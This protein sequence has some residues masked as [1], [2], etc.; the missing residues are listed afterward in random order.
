LITTEAQRLGFQAI[1]FAPAC[2]AMGFDRFERWLEKGFDAGMSYLRERREAYRHPRNVL[3]NVQTI[4][5]L[6]LSYKKPTVSQA[7]EGSGRIAS[8]ATAEV[9]YHD[10]IHD[11]LKQ[12]QKAVR[13]ACPEIGMRGIVDTAPLLEREYAQL[14]GLGW[15]GKNTL[16]LNRS[17]GSYFFLAALLVDIPL[18][19]DSAFESDHCGTCRACL[20]ACPTAAFPEPYVLDA[21]KCISYWTI[22]HRG[23]IPSEMQEGIGDWLF[24]CD[25]CQQVC[26]W[27]RK[28]LPTE[29]RELA[30]E[31]ERGQVD[32][33]EL[34]RMTPEVFRQRYRK[35]PLW[36]SKYQG[37]VRNAIIVATNQRLAPAL[38]DIRRLAQHEDSV[39][40]TTAQ[41]S[42]QR[43]PEDRADSLQPSE[44]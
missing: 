33:L 8:Y 43:W 40:A 3:E 34:L 28:P 9:D 42:L 27:N 24:G 19:S 44:S 16:L 26:P 21:G 41:Q 4:V 22:E 18:P 17:L 6:G 14:A 29:D 13:A 5:M 10:V 37:I 20:D 38:P 31:G 39:I 36:R 25:V 7:S 30:A 15:V 12:L 1:G 35:T 11:R 32:L 2:D 23:P